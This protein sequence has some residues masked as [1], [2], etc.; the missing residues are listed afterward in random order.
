MSDGAPIRLSELIGRSQT[1]P[2]EKTVLCM[3]DGD[4][5]SLRRMNACAAEWHVHR[6]SDEL[7]IILS[8]AVEIDVEDNTHRLGE[9]DILLVKAGLRHRARTDDAAVLLVIDKAAAETA[10]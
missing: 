8:G 6:D 2:W 3:F 5:L 10:T 1:N 9:N 4:R 7:F